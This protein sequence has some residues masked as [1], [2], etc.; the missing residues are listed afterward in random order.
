[1]NQKLT[2]EKQIGLKNDKEKSNCNQGRPS[3][4]GQIIL[5]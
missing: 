2:K 1:L 3:W 5:A 4:D